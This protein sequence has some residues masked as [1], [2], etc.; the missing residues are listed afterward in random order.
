[1]LGGAYVLFYFPIVIYAVI[2]PQQVT[3]GDDYVYIILFGIHYL[4]FIF[5][6]LIYTVFTPSF[7]HKE[8]NLCT[9]LCIKIG[10]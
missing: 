8:K 1:M 9:K 4:V 2:Y 5:N 3:K 7:I 10:K 6:P